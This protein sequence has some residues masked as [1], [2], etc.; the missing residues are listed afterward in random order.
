[1]PFRLGATSRFGTFLL[2]SL[3]FYFIDGATPAFAQCTQDGNNVTCS[4]DTPGG[5]STPDQRPR[6]SVLDACVGDTISLNDNNA[7]ANFGTI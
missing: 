3:T 5:F 2:A 7:V 4:G 6:L 1:M